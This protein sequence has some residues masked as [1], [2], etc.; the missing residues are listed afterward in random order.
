MIV[1]DI[2]RRTVRCAYP[3]EALAEAG[4]SMIE[5]DVGA[6]L[7]IERMDPS[8]RPIGIL[9]DR[10][11]VRGQLR[12]A[13]DI[14]CLTVGEVMTRSPFTLGADLGLADAVQALNA[15]FV[16]RAPVVDRSGALVGIVTLDDLL[17]ALAQQLAELALLVGS[18]ARGALSGWASATG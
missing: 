3:D 10:D 6:L 2:C 8:R 4:R 13:T 17:P 5:H 18:Q 1:G 12:H 11:V 9:T 15:K 14:F 16:R 7:V